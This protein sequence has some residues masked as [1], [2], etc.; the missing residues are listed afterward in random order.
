M[1]SEQMPKVSV[2][3]PVYNGA[4]YM[5][6]AIDSALAQTY[7]NMEII[8]VNDGSTDDGVTDRIARSY[9]DR[10]LY[11]S[12]ENGGV[13]SALNEGIRHMTGDYVSWLS[14]DDVYAPEKIAC[15]VEGLAKA[16][17]EKA[18][19]LCAHCFIDQ[20][21]RRLPKTARQ[22][23]SPGCHGWREALAE[24]L[25]HGTFN[26][27]AMLIPKTAFDECGLF[28]EGLRFS[29]DFLMWMQFFFAG[30]SVVYTADEYVFSRIHP[31]QVTNTSRE[32]FQKDSAAIADMV[33]PRLSALEEDDT[34]F[35]Y[36]F[37]RRNAKYGN[38]AVVRS[39]M[40]VGRIRALFTPKHRIALKL[41]LLYGEV[42]PTLRKFYYR[43][44]VKVKPIER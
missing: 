44:L 12:K 34:H 3:I 41:R 30:Y 42:R 23:F 26:G 6:E 16:E 36:A 39:C 22:R 13:S 43:L 1:F 18:I 9:G 2:V 14:H 27:C 33:I 4:N 8:V 38:R 10:I 17:E 35:L 37:A 7:G 15:Q 24:E 21:S 28:H 19:A 40:E 29:Q 25:A 20:N 11:I 31:K 32:L 5:R